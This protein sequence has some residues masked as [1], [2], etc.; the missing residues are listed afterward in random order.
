MIEVLAQH[1]GG[2]LVDLRERDPDVGGQ[3]DH[4]LALA[5]G[6]EDRR[7]ATG[8]GLAVVRE[9]EG[10]GGELVERLDRHHAVALEHRLVG[11]VVAGDRPGVAQREFGC[12]GRASGLEGDDGD[13]AIS[14]FAQGGAEVVR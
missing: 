14:G 11:R 12:R 1:G 4:Q 5:A 6:V 10:G 9:E 3:V 13:A 8:R 7:E 2:R